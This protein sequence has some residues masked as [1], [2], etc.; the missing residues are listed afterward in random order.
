MLDKV[1]SWLH[2]EHH[3]LLK[4]AVQSTILQAG[5]RCPLPALDMPSD[6]VRVDA[7]EVAQAM[8]HENSRQVQSNN[9]R[10]N[11]FPK[12]DATARNSNG[13]KGR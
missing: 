4:L 8:R 12:S 6:V 3:A 2:S 11:D 5:P 1:A 9:L 13:F 10:I 7:H